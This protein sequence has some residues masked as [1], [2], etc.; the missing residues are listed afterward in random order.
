MSKEMVDP[1]PSLLHH[2]DDSVLQ[3]QTVEKFRFIDT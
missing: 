3:H 2:S 1:T